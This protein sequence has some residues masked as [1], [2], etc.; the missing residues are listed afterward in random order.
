MS[1]KYTKIVQSGRLVEIY[2]YQYSP[3][4]HLGLFR[5]DRGKANTRQRRNR[6]P[7]NVS[8]LCAKF[9]RLVWANLDD[10]ERSPAL[11][12]LTFRDDLGVAD[13][14][15]LFSSFRRRLEKRFTDVRYIAVP[16]FGTQ[17]TCRLHFHVLIWGLDD[18]IISNERSS[19]EL[20][21][22]WG[23]GFVDIL[24]LMVQSNWRDIWQSICQK[25]FM[26]TG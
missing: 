20:A 11:L 15:K 25:Q 19:R 5:R 14:F 10:R 26:K 13:G 2:E 23:N 9:K 7:D 18:F 16:E 8:R 24:K 21:S 1:Q 4:K 17:G 3:N 6:R 12:T 22:L